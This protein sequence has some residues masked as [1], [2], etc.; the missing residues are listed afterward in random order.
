VRPS[1][2]TAARDASYT[3]IIDWKQ[4]CIDYDAFASPTQSL[5]E[6]LDKNG[7]DKLTKDELVPQQSKKPVSEQGHRRHRGG[8]D[9]CLATDGGTST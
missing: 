1:A 8:G 6:E 7:D 5:F 9:G 4:G 3:P 2:K